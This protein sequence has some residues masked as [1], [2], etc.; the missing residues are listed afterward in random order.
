MDLLVPETW[1][2]LVERWDEREEFRLDTHTPLTTTDEAK[3]V[4]SVL[5]IENTHTHTHGVNNRAVS[6]KLKTFYLFFFHRRSRANYVTAKARRKE[7][8]GDAP[9]RHGGI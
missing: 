9:P 5:H 7:L 3:H 4:Q 1:A 8:R 2:F 6:I